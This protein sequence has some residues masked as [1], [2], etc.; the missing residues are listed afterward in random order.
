MHSLTVEPNL[1][2]IRILLSMT[3][4]NLDGLK[5]CINFQHNLTIN[6]IFS[7]DFVYF[8]RMNKYY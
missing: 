4:L 1:N 2:S 8:H 7:D 6:L 5:F 3:Q